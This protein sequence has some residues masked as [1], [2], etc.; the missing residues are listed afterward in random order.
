MIKFYKPE[1]LNDVMKIWL[2][3][4]IN[5]HG[6]IEKSYW[7]DNYSMVKELM[8]QA[9]IYIYE[10]NEEIK[11]FIGMDGNYIEGIFVS[12]ELQSKGIGKALLD[13]VKKKNNEL[14]L[15][16]YKKNDR[17]VKFY[18][19]EGFSISAEQIDQNTGEAEFNMMWVAVN[20]DL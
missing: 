12:N 6:F 2:N 1:Y 18:L 3:T 13:Y 9:V 17:A 16:V 14:N 5:A 19:R 8:P 10:H 20:V 4:N 11:A 7:Y 15:N